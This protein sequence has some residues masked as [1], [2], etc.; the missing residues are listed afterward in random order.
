ME[1][2]KLKIGIDLDD[3]ILNWFEDFIL[4]CKENFGYELK[5]ERFIYFKEE[6][7][8]SNE[9]FTK[10]LEEYVLQGK[11]WEM[12]FFIDFLDVFDELSSLFEIYFITARISD[13][14]IKT[15][16]FLKN[17]I[18]DNFELLY[19]NDFENLRKS[20]ICLNK[21]ISIMVEDDAGHALG[22]AKSGIRCFLLDKPWNQNCEHENIIRVK[23]WNEI[24]EKIMEV[25][26]GIY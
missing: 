23:D 22:C 13:N 17:K 8:G 7:F 10:A 15:K 9:N 16:E 3:T 2:K 12:E 18:G 4:F 24:L 19:K 25:E 1:K 11:N 21:N 5:K 14:K 26:N 20:D 6:D